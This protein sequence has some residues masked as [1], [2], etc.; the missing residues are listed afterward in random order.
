M[1][2][3][4]MGW[5]F[6]YDNIFQPK[7]EGHGHQS[8]ERQSHGQCHQ[9]W[10]HPVTG[11]GQGQQRGSELEGKQ[12]SPLA[13]YQH[14]STPWRRQGM[15]TRDNDAKKMPGEVL[16]LETCTAMNTTKFYPTIR[17]NTSLS[18]R[19]V[20]QGQHISGNNPFVGM[21]NCLEETPQKNEK[22]LE[23]KL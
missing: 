8:S 3:K 7:E 20:L 21:K 18:C 22:Q 5:L 15:T 4:V 11:T 16:W 6:C 17:S 23:K 14:A 1:G 2:W 10:E 13:S 12:Y 19:H 9:R